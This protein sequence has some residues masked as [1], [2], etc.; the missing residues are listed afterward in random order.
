MNEKFAALYPIIASAALLSLYIYQVNFFL[1]CKSITRCDN[2]NYNH[3]LLFLQAY[4]NYFPSLFIIPI[5]I[6]YF[7]LS[8]RALIKLLTPIANRLIPDSVPKFR[9]N[10]PFINQSKRQ[11]DLYE[12]SSHDLICLFACNGIFIWYYVEKVIIY[13]L[14]LLFL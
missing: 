2:P 10:L 12:Y 5:K 13:N 8:I 14:V 7:C 4:S 3:F 6:Y 11:V 9:F 1:N